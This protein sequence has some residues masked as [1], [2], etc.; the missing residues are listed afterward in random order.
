MLTEVS[1]RAKDIFKAFNIE[2]PGRKH[3][4]NFSGFR[5]IVLIRFIKN[6]FPGFLKRKSMVCN[7]SKIKICF[8]PSK[9]VN[10]IKCSVFLSISPE[11]S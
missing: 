3:S 11:T 2:V 4:Y 7:G 10:S 6:F 5:V 9:L 1:E 8:I